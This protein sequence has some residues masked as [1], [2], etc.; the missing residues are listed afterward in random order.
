MYEL[1]DEIC[2][3]IE[4]QASKVEIMSASQLHN[5]RLSRIEKNKQ[6]LN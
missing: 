3:S 6:T 2:K 1:H 4:K 5:W